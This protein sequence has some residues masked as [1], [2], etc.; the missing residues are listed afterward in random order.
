MK[1]KANKRWKKAAKIIPGGNMLYSKRAE[2][3][4]PK[5]W[6]TYYSKTKDAL[7]WDKEGNKYIDMIFA[8]GTNVLGYNHPLI[9]KTIISHIALKSEEREYQESISKKKSELFPPKKKITNKQLINKIFAYS[10][11]KKAANK[12]AEYSTLYPATNSASASGKSNGARFVSAKIDIKKGS[13][14]L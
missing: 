12:K 13:M 14:T 1:L 9:E 7:V 6:P 3:F 10:P 11:K 5:F 2:A 4:L 8:V